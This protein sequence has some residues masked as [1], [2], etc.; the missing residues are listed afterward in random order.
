LRLARGLASLAL[1]VA[2]ASCGP[3]PPEA[4]RLVLEP[5]SYGDLPG[6]GDDHVAAALPA[7]QRSCAAIAKLADDAEH[8]PAGTTLKARDWRAPCAALAQVPSGDDDAAR[9][10]FAR[11]FRPFVARGAKETEGLFTGYYEPELKGAREQGGA[12][13][14]PLF[15]RPAD[16]VTV[17]LGLFDDSLKGKHVAGRVD[18]GQLKPYPTRAEIEAGALHDAAPTL[19]W[20][21]DAIELF[22]LQIQGSGRVTLPDGT[23]VRVGYAAANGR[24]YRAIGKLL[25]ER[26]AMK[27][28]DITLQSLKAWLREHPGAA[29]GLM[30][31]NPSYV[32]FR[33]V[34]GEGPLGAE[35]V[36]LT[37]GRSLAVDQRFLNFGAPIWLDAESPEGMGR[38][39]RL[40]VAQDRGG[41]I[42]GPVRGDLFW[43]AGAE[44]EKLAGP[45][46]SKGRYWVLLPKEAEAKPGS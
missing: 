30:D 19:L 3:S 45:M 23:V 11:W 29:K 22:F 35:G 10:Y 25:A 32:F 6:W 15:G 2:L 46:K 17:N 41:A 44:A 28:E 24:S 16:L 21:D 1:I 43:G 27:V 37:P 5:A 36:A 18:S 7:L 26:G 13:A 9:A 38:L 34:P 40:V 42:K 33:E 12:F 31:E 14:I 39:R 8:G 4:E 20:I